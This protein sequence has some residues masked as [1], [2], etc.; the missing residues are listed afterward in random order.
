MSLFCDNDAILAAARQY[1]LWDPN[2]ETASQVEELINNNNLQVLEK[3]LSSRLAFG[4]AGLRGPMGP[5]YNRMNDLV[6]LHTAQG[7]SVYLENEELKG[8][9]SN[10]KDMVS[11]DMVTV[12]Y[13]AQQ[14]HDKT[15][16]LLGNRN[17]I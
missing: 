11:L 15:F 16:C 4:T 6:I 14:D 3:I 5:G 8:N 12:V 7:L 2:P 1:V 9:F 17:W 10:V 13:S